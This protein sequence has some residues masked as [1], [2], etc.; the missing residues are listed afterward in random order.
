GK[1]SQ[2]SRAPRSSSGP[3]SVHMSCSNCRK[4]LLKGQTAFQ[5]KGSPALFCSTACLTSSL[6]SKGGSKL[7]NNCQKSITRPQ[8]VVLASDTNG[9]M[10]EFCGQSCMNSFNYKKQ[11]LS[12]RPADA[13]PK[14]PQTQSLCSMCSRFSTV[15]SAAAHR[16]IA[17]LC[18]PSAANGPAAYFEQQEQNLLSIGYVG[19]T[20][21]G[22]N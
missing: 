16:T 15:S 3:S 13:P 10:K 5:R 2:R 20:P 11:G 6:P 12:L 8:D 4:N 19:R 14:T 17:G 1:G 21:Q 9:T 22:L 18:S 7:C